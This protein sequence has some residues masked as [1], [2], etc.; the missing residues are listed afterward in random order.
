MVDILPPPPPPPTTT[1]ATGK[2]LSW[3]QHVKNT[4]V[5]HLCWVSVFEREGKN[6]YPQ[7]VKILSYS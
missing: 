1:A 3:L 6:I 2:V 7:G 5:D 4:G